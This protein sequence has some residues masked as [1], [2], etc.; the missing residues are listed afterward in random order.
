VAPCSLAQIDR[1]FIVVMMEAVSTS[2]T[3]VNFYETTRR[4]VLEGNHTRRREKV[5]PHNADGLLG[6]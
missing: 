4:N 1:H 3:F 6:L 5:T 2:E